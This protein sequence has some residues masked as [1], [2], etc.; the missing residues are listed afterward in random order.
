MVC[1]VP[2]CTR[3][4]TSRGWCAT[5][6]KRWQRTG[7]TG[8]PPPRPTA[9]GVDGC[10]RP[11]DGRGLCHGHL[12]RELRT[13][14]VQAHI[15]LGRRRQPETC[16]AEDCTNP[17]AS[18]GLCTTHLWRLRRY[19]TTSSEG[20]RRV[21]RTGD[22]GAAPCCEEGCSAPAVA[23]DRCAACYKAA[24]RAGTVKVDKGVRVVTGDG[25]LTHGYW[26]VPVPREL[27]HLT[28]GEHAVLEHRLV[29]AQHLGRPLLPDE[30]VHHVNGVKTDN[31]LENLELWT[32]S[33]P[34]G[35]RV[36]DKV[37]WAVGLLRRYA[38]HLLRDAPE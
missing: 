29:M 4:A 21:V 9:C 38:P 30:S 6:Y 25:H 37:A 7:T 32:T 3:P 11:V 23:R 10:E 5:H 1:T 19:G 35:Q 34:S 13:G 18:H 26:K 28:N 27:R 2:D 15:P 20:M 36:E 16:T 14:D 12:Q 8:D 33:H 24:L 17:S 22:G 31:R